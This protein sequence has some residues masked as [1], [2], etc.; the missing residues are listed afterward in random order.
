MRYIKRFN[1]SKSN[2]EYQIVDNESFEDMND[3]D[4][5]K[6]EFNLIKS[7]FNKSNKNIKHPS[8]IVFKDSFS[9]IKTVGTTFGIG[10]DIIPS[11][12]FIVFEDADKMKSE[13]YVELICSMD[14]FKYEDEW[15]QVIFREDYKKNYRSNTRRNTETYKCDQFEGL[16]QLLKDKNILR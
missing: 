5:S 11:H 2:G 3:V 8:R 1:E 13:K 10:K 7:L 6:K 9:M 15:Y 4:I 12:I 14:I 16:I